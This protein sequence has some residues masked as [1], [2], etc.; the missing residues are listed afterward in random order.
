[1]YY[2]WYDDYIVTY[3]SAISIRRFE[4]WRNDTLQEASIR[5]WNVF[6][7]KTFQADVKMLFLTLINSIFVFRVLSDRLM[8]KDHFHSNHPPTQ[9]FSLHL[10]RPLLDAV[11]ACTDSSWLTAPLGFLL[12]FCCT[13]QGGTAR[14][15]IADILTYQSR[16]STGGINHTYDSCIM[17]C[18][19]DGSECP[20][21]V[22]A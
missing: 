20:R 7:F 9:V 22:H 15:V 11:W 21:Q 18:R 10:I 12:W 14:R 6:A 3:C 8:V 17:L 1:M 13:C 2:M 19:W 4:Y 5:L 16:R